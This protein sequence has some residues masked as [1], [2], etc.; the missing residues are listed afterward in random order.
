MRIPYHSTL[1]QTSGPYGA[2]GKAAIVEANELEGWGDEAV[3]SANKRIPYHSTLVQLND[4]EDDDE[5]SIPEKIELE[6]AVAIPLDFKLV[7]SHDDTEME[8]LEN[9]DVGVPINFRFVNIPT[10]NGNVVRME[11]I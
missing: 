4:E 3:D 7:Q 1:L 8:T 9:D 2:E 10:I 5:D 11:G 6:A